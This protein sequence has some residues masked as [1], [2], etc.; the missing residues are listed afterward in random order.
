VLDAAL[1]LLNEGPDAGMGAV[2]AAAG[3][4]RQTVYALF[5]SR[6]DLLAAVIDRFT[7][8]T[9]VAMDAAGPDDG[10]APAALLRVLEAAWDLADRYQGIGRLAAEV[11]LPHEEE[12]QCHEPV[13]AR[14]A[15]VIERGRAAGE[16]DRS[17]PT[18]WLVAA[19]IG[20]A[21][22]AAGEATA[23]RLSRAQARAALH[24]GVLRLTA[25]PRDPA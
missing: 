10:P 9:A 13:A 7:A 6:R 22:A 15:R 24:T 8:E 19:V 17:L 2:A 18:T 12:R 23:G 20:L 5:P 4:T 16:F 14:L 3:V 21:H 11:P 25:V 1:R